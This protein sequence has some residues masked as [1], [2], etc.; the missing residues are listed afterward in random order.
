MAYA[1]NFYNRTMVWITRRWLSTKSG[2]RPLVALKNLPVKSGINIEAKLSFLPHCTIFAKF[3]I[4]TKYP[5]SSKL[6]F[7]LAI[8]FKQTH[9]S[10]ASVFKRRTKW[11]RSR[12]KRMPK[13]ATRI[14]T[15]LRGSCSKSPSSRNPTWLSRL[16][17]RIRKACSNAQMVRSG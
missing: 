10:R 3:A 4:S 7:G 15:P 14:S 2:T 1:A 6:L 5:L 16:I 8:T 17:S 9:T 13:E 12:A 11:H